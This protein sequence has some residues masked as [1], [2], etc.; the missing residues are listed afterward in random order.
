MAHNYQSPDVQEVADVVGDS[1][2]LRREAVHVKADIIVFCG[3]HFQAE[4]IKLSSPKKKVLLPDKNARCPMADMIRPDDL[5]ALQARH[6]EAVTLCYVNS[7]AE[8]KALCDYCCTSDN[9]LN[10]ARDMMTRH[11]EIIFVPDKH[12][13]Q[14]VSAQVRHHFI[15]WEGCCPVHDKISLENIVELK[16]KHPR[17][18]VIVHPECKPSVTAV[19]DVVTSTEGMSRHVSTSGHREFII[20]TETSIIHR[21][22]KEN[23]DKIFYMASEKAICEDM[24][25]ITPEKI[26]HSLESLS[27]EITLSPEIME[28]ARRCIEEMPY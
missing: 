13:A 3:V 6:P 14:Y 15:T 25:K 18:R 8:T 22:K 12:L 7:S 19:A 16:N 26:L 17:A 4:T 11:K 2:G 10:I 28:K 23:P 27:Y 5:K 24:K 21:L 9:V 1:L 20:G